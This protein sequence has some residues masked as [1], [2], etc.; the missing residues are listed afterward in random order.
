M[1]C[2]ALDKGGFVCGFYPE[3]E[4][5]GFLFEVHSYHGPCPL[6]R[7]DHEPR[8]NTP[9]GFYAAWERF[10]KLSTEKQASYAV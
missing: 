7:K 4:Y 1:P 8:L 5:E 9:K 2:Y 10:E 3:Y 6:R